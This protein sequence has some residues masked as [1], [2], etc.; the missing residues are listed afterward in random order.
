MGVGAATSEV[1]EDDEEELG[2]PLFGGSEVVEGGGVLVLLGV[3]LVL[4]LVGEGFGLGLVV[5][6]GLGSSPP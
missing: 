5:V 4:V 1:E 6:V 3:M 2:L